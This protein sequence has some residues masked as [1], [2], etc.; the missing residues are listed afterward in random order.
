[1]STYKQDAAG[2]ILDCNTVLETEEG[3]FSVYLD[4]VEVE[5]TESELQDIFDKAVELEANAKSE[6]YIGLRV[7]EYR[8]LNQFELMY[9]DKI[10]GTTSWL[11]AID[12]IKIR[13]PK[14][15]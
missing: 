6:E 13:F 8:Q 10:N 11:D 15:R 12:A 1:M 2:I 9:D 3:D 14:P 7:K 4:G 5:I